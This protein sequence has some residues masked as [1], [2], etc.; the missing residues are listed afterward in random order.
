MNFKHLENFSA[1]RV[2]ALFGFHPTVLADIL[3]VVLPELEDRRT[4][5]LAEREN[6]KRP[7]LAH[8]G[9][10]RTVLPVP[11]FHAL[12]SISVRNESPQAKRDG[13]RSRPKS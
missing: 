12:R 4:K 11:P 2:K 9:K 8:D 1:S 10:P 13:T 6:R 7:P 3:M 5:R